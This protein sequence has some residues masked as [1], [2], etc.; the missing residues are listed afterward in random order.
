[1]ANIEFSYFDETITR[2]HYDRVEFYELTCEFSREVA[3]KS[4]KKIELYL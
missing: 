4:Y 3:L 2:I 1:M